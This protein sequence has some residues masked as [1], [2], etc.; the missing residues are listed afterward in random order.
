[1]DKYVNTDIYN[2]TDITE[3]IKSNFI[4]EEEDT[5]AAST[6][7]F[8]SSIAADTFRESIRISAKM[9]NETIYSKA[10]LESSIITHAMILG[11]NGIFA[12]PAVMKVKLVI[13]EDDLLRIMGNSNSITID[14]LWKIM[15]DDYEFHLDYDI[16]LTRTTISGNKNVYSARY[17]TSIP[18]KLSDITNPYI[19]PPT[20]IILEGTT[21]IAFDVVIRQVFYETYYKKFITNNVIDNKTFMFSFENQLCNF[22]I[23]VTKGGT[24]TIVEPVYEGTNPKT[25]IFCYYSFITSNK[26]RVKFDRNIFIPELGSEVTVEIYTS[27]GKDGN[28]PYNTNFE[29]FIISDRFD[30]KNTSALF[31]PMSTSQ[32]GENKKTTSELQSLLPIEATARG[33]IGNKDDLSAHFN[34]ENSDNSRI[35]FEDK[36]MNQFEN[37][38][39]TYLA[40]KDSNNNMIPTNTIDVLIPFDEF[41]TINRSIGYS[42]Y[43][44]KQGCYIL[45]DGNKAIVKT[46][47]SYKDITDAKFVYTIPFTCSI[48]DSQLQSSYY[49]SLMDDLYDLSY[50]YINLES[51]LQFVT[52]NIQW[53][54]N[55]I[56]DSNMYSLSFQLVQ[57]INSDMGV[58]VETPVLDEEGNP[59]GEVTVTNN[60]KVIII[61]YKNGNAYRYKVAEMTSYDLEVFTFQFNAT[62][63]SSDLINEYNNIRINNLNIIGQPED[64]FDYGYFNANTQVKIYVLYKGDVEYGRYNIDDYVPGLFGYTLSNV[65]S[66][67]GGIYFFKNYSGVISSLVSYTKYTKVIEQDMDWSIKP[68]TNNNMYLDN[69]LLY[70]PYLLIRDSDITLTIKDA[71]NNTV[72]FKT[73]FRKEKEDDIDVYN[74]N[75]SLRD[76]SSLKGTS[77]PDLEYDIDGN[78]I[79][80]EEDL[81]NNEIVK[82]IN[83]SYTRIVNENT[84]VK[85]T[86]ECDTNYF[87]LD[88]IA[89]KEDINSL[90][91]KEQKELEYNL[92]DYTTPDVVTEEKDAFK[93]SSVPVLKKSYL[94]T[95]SKVNYIVDM[96]NEK[97]D[98]IENS[99]SLLESPFSIDIKLVNTYGP[100]KLYTLKD[101]NALDRVNLSLKFDIKLKSNADK[102]VVSY[103]IDDIKTQIESINKNLEDIHM[104]VLE[105]YIMNK[106]KNAIVYIECMGINDYDQTIN[107]LYLS[108]INTGSI[109]EFICINT[110]DDETEPDISITLV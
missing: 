84:F 7:G 20:T 26:I 3:Q 23:K 78:Y 104:K 39:Y 97:K 32:Y 87:T 44:I 72:Y 56:K 66:I 73:K 6:L 76:F 35:I 43:T 107:H 36:T 95:E 92:I 81:L 62:F 100:S 59:T 101:G 57:N 89:S 69:G 16:V 15:I 40:L 42:R 2:I 99:N 74:T 48:T 31:I 98:F 103:I 29:S 61:L 11:I 19:N 13:N 22:S 38:Y 24:T 109:P 54:R 67:N 91:N 27:L 52:T 105:D 10:T 50:D 102:N 1:M 28:F 33:S 53:V 46:N 25:D 96:L 60:F 18:N 88:Y 49:M 51:N 93:L 37:S 63:E 14:R 77:Y 45:S 94:D 41:D 65:Y 9:A 82:N 55:Y 30:Y 17:D 70:I 80:K 108:E 64:E 34:S 21:A 68:C 58:V 79:F 86:L 5:L 12:K 90:L 47:P 85:I 110:K 4:N 83:E 75:W 71:Y 8:M 106:Y